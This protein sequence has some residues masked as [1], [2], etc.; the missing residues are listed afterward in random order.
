MNATSTLRPRAGD[1][2][3]IVDVQN[4]FLPGGALAVPQGSEVVSTLN[5]Y[6]GLFAAQGLPVFATRDWHP[7]DHCSFRK[8]GGPW[9]A[10]CVAGTQGAQFAPKLA[11]PPDSRVVSKATT[12]ERDAYSGFAGT[13]LDAMLRRE[14]VHRVFVGGLA[15][16]YCVLNTVKDAR[17][18]GYEVVLL[19]DAIRAVDLK[20]GDGRRAQEEMQRLGAVPADVESVEA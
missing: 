18:L 6:A 16:D 11:L 14:N 1:A 3:I 12:P 5:R 20:S 13:E 2:L 15:T 17:T 19:Q 4:D 8:Q 7:P 10:H 9:P